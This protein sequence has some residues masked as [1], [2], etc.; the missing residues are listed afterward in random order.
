MKNGNTTHYHLAY[1]LI[2]E[3][4]ETGKNVEKTHKKVISWLEKIRGTVSGAPRIYVDKTLQILKEDLS[5]FE[6]YE[7]ENKGEI[8][9]PLSNE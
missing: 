9:F 1:N 7:E 3:K 8:K 4:R 2:S 6:K 5:M